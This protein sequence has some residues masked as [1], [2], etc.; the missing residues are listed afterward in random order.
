MTYNDRY[1]IEAKP[2]QNKPKPNQK[3]DLH[4]R[5]F[6]LQLHLRTVAK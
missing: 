5:K 3:I 4:G 1:A 6:N 2:N